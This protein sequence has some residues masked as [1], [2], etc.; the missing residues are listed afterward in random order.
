MARNPAG[1][2]RCAMWVGLSTSMPPAVRRFHTVINRFPRNH[3]LCDTP[4]RA[5]SD[6]SHEA[7][8]GPYFNRIML[9]SLSASHRSGHLVV[10]ALNLNGM[11]KDLTRSI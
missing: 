1:D 8:T 2:G 4:R 7:R 3:D 9:P 6:S 5:V 11:I 10:I